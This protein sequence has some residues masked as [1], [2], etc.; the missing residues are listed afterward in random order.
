MKIKYSDM[1]QFTKFTAFSISAGAIQAISY[2][3]MD[4]VMYLDY[5]TAYL[6]ALTLSVLWNFTINRR[7]TFKSANNVPVAMTKIFIFYLI[8]TPLSTWWGTAL[9]SINVNEYI[10]L[11]GTMI[12][13]FVTEFLYSRQFIYKNQMNTRIPK[14]KRA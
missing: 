13:N 14:E 12:I 8:F 11:G 1:I 7:F 6:T 3:F 4:K 9:V 10:V 2:T 5:D